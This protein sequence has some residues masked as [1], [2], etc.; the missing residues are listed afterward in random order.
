MTA[1]EIKAKREALGLTL[2][3]MARRLDVA[4]GTVWRWEQSRMTPTKRLQKA[5]RRLK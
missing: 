5:I 4:T 2:E 3:E 1:D